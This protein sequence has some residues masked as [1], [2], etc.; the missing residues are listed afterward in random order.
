MYK[1][2]IHYQKTIKANSFKIRKTTDDLIYNISHIADMSVEEDGTLN[3]DEDCECFSEGIRNK[4]NELMYIVTDFQTNT[5][6]MV[7]KI[8]KVLVL[9]NKY[10]YMTKNC[11]LKL[12]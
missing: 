5:L 11:L 6:E 3:I 8:Y 10:S 4:Y 2:I 9:F 1:E 12:K 7:K